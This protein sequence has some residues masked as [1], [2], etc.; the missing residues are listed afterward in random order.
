MKNYIK[1]ATVILSLVMA[2]SVPV[3]VHAEEYS[4]EPT[5][6]GVYIAITGET[7]DFYSNEDIYNASISM[8]DSEALA[9]YN[10][11]LEQAP[12][13][14][15]EG[16]DFAVAAL[17][18]FTQYAVEEGI[19]EDTVEQ[20][21]A[22]TKAV[23][24]AEFKLVVAGGNVLGYTAAA[25][26]LNHSLQDNPSNLSYGSTTDMAKQ[27]AGSTECRTIVNQFK[28]DV[29][30]TNYVRK[31]NSGTTT[32]NS[33]T[34]LHLA[35]NNVNYSAT[36]VKSNGKWTLTITF[37]DTY[38]FDAQSWKNAMTDNALVTILNNYAAYAQSIGAIV[39]YNVTVTVQ[40]TFQQEK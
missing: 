37:T 39:P 14:I 11:Y 33:T 9:L 10:Q 38:D 1:R 36:G 22:I 16:E 4:G 12:A 17:E 15:S 18:G 23:V 25:T 20:R 13:S 27:I 29:T 40:T 30:G 35:Y 8:Y 28:S 24:R 6:E 7:E 34:D 5:E 21:A 26:L 31:T 2:M 19:I 32:L 3:N